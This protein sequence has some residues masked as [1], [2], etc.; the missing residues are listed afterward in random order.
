M[1]ILLDTGLSVTRKLLK[2]SK[3][4]FLLVKAILVKRKHVV[5][6]VVIIITFLYRGYLPLLWV[7]ES[8]GERLIMILSLH[9]YC[10]TNKIKTRKSQERKRVSIQAFL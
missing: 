2:R 8:R 1:L 7:E 4:T 10:E 5:V 3:Y 6:N 9:G